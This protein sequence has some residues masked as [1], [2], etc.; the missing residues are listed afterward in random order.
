MPDRPKPRW[1]HLTPDRFLIGLLL[2]VGV[3]FV[4]EWFCW[5]PF[6]ERKG[7]TVLIAIGAVCGA[8]PFLL[9]VA[10]SVP[11]VMTLFGQSGG[12]QFPKPS[13]KPHPSAPRKTRAAFECSGA[14]LF[15]VPSDPEEAPVTEYSGATRSG[16]GVVG[17][18]LQPTATSITSKETTETRE[19][20]A[21][22]MN[23]LPGRTRGGG[24]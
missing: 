11:Q 22:L 3:L 14:E 17:D 19:L 23:H 6:N 1:Y 8:V 10:T 15:A 7:W 21:L 5:F 20:R 16:L 4:S 2:V 12:N 13:T 9:F 24:A 18:W